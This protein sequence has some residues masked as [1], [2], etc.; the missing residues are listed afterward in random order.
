MSRY[1]IQI[2][3]ST[4]LFQ[5]EH[6]AKAA[7]EIVKFLKASGTLIETSQTVIAQHVSHEDYRYRRSYQ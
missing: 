1:E 4:F 3:N 2:Q 6:D 5:N 7:F